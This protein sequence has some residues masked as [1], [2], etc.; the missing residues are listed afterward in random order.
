MLIPELQRHIAV[1]GLD[2][3]QPLLRRDVKFW[4]VVSIL[5]PS[6]LTPPLQGARKVHRAMF[7][8][9][10]DIVFNDDPD[11][12]PPERED[13]EAIFD[14]VYGLP[15][16]PVLFHCRA[17]ISRSAAAAL[18]MIVRGHFALGNERCMERSIEQLLALRPQAIPNT[19]MLRLGFEL[20]MEKKQAAA[21]AQ[22]INVHP[23][24]ARNRTINPSRS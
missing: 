22:A 5:E 18:L 11:L 19:R 2:E 10:E 24:L 8:D 6:T 12:R 17:G 1:C 14:F 21:W 3:V 4:N 15:R 20:F 7:H 16:E 23:D 13:I 9:V